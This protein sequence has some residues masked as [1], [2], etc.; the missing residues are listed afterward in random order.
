MMATI[1]LS[2]LAALAV[3]VGAA[4]L[5]RAHLA[6]TGYSPIR[7]AVSDYGVGSSSRSYYRVLV[8]GLG[9]G[10]LL[11]AAALW[12]YGGT[13]GVLWLAAFAVARLAIAYFPTDLPDGRSTATGRVHRFL[14]IAAFATIAFAA[15]LVSNSLAEHHVWQGL[16]GTLRL[17]ANLVSFAAIATLFVGVVPNLRRRIFGL[18]ERAFYAAAIAWLLVGA[19]GLAVHA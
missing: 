18:V 17:L 12:H 7:D 5:L 9:V 19:I 11:F 3:A 1:A 10:A 8:V 2:A 6:P 14:A 15:P 16:G 13:S 4:A